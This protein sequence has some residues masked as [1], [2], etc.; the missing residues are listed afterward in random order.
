MAGVIMRVSG[1]AVLPEVMV[2]VI[3]VSAGV[4]RW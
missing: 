3:M 2:R 1:L 4:L